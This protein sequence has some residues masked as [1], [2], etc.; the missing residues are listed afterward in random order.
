MNSYALPHLLD[1][2]PAWLQE[3]A[4]KVKAG[5]PSPAE[6]LGAMRIEV[7]EKLILRPAATYV[8]LT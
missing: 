1:V 4:T 7:L 6:V 8:M 3:L 5:L 2:S